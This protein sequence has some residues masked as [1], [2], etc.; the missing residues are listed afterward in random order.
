MS[1]ARTKAVRRPAV[2]ED[3]MLPEYD[4]TRARRGA[5]AARYAQGSNIIVLEPDVA[6]AF[7]DAA[8][9]NEALR[10]LIRLAKPKARRPSGSRSA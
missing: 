8:S 1:K 5:T 7:P 9:V 6:A 2:R 3:T 10:A 4:F